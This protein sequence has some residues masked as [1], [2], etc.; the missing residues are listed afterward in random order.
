MLALRNL[1]F[2]IILYSVDS[3]EFQI[4]LGSVSPHIE[5]S[6]SGTAREKMYNYDH[7]RTL[8]LHV[9]KHVGH[10]QAKYM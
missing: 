4:T 9:P 1:N 5:V 8:K 2:K 7:L 6:P 10:V 3:T